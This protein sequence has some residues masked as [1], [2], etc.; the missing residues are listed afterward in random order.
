MTQKNNPVLIQFD[1]AKCNSQ[2][3]NL[4]QFI[5]FFKDAIDDFNSLGI[6][7]FDNK[8]FSDLFLT[9][10]E[11]LFDAFMKDRPLEVGGMKVSKEKLFELLEKPT[12]YFSLIANI[13]SLHEKIKKVPHYITHTGFYNLDENFL[14]FFEFNESE[15]V[16]K[17]DI[18]KRLRTINE[19][20][21][22]NEDGILVHTL[23]S[24]LIKVFNSSDLMIASV[25]NNPFQSIDFFLK[26]FMQ[27]N[28]IT[29]EFDINTYRVKLVDDG[30]IKLTKLSIP[31][32]K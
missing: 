32:K 20:W 17:Q 7:K 27:F 9:P 25:E 16:L 1:E 14:N 6:G 24:D 21:I 18:K 5:S 10:Q 12:G 11:F 15:I 8:N 2:T 22:S 31:R 28:P 19:V 13:Q 29:R 4:Q 26:T 23:F 30:T 3:G